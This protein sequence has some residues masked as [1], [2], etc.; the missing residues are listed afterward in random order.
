M[1]LFPKLDYTQ[2]NLNKSSTIFG[3]N[4]QMNFNIY[5]EV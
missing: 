3:V 2:S 4:W 5:V 1:T